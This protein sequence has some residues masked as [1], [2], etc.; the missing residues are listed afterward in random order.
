VPA[1][2]SMASSETVPLSWRRKVRAWLVLGRISNLPTVWSNCLAAWLLGG[3]GPWG[4]LASVVIGASLLYTAGMFLN[5]ACDVNFDRRYRPERP[6]VS[7]LVGAGAVWFAG[8]LLMALGWLTIWTTGSRAASYGVLLVATI[9]AYDLVHKKTILAPLLMAGCRFLLYLVGA[10]AAAKGSVASALWPAAGLAGYIVGLSYLARR[11]STSPGGPS[12]AKPLLLAPIALALT[13]SSG[14]G[15]SVW[16]AAATTTLWVIWCVSSP[17]SWRSGFVPGGIAGL[18]AGIVWV[19]WLA[20]AA[21]A[22]G[23]CAVFVGLFLLA[24][25]AQRLA[26]AT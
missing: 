1:E 3:G 4:K 17:K 21:A 26:P 23:L 6:I 8:G 7:G 5:D 13:L 11:E 9:I 25:L 10:A 15:Q 24:V 20:T 18:L 12:W 14:S 2:S 19:D 22:P 16:I